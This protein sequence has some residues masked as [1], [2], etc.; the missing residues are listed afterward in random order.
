MNAAANAAT[1]CD[2]AETVG[3]DETWSIPFVHENTHPWRI[4]RRGVHPVGPAARVQCP[5]KKRF[6][7]KLS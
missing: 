1:V 5:G 3:N 6:P 7:M 2:G 4:E